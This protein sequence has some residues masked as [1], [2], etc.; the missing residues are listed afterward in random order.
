MHAP[1]KT[2][3]LPAILAATAL[4]VAVLGATPLGHAAGTLVLPKNSVR[5]AQVVNGSL[6]AVDLSKKARSTLKG[7]PGTQGPRGAVG[8]AGAPGQRGATGPQGPRGLPGPTGARATK[9]LVAVKAD[10]S[11]TRS[12]GGTI[13]VAHGT[14][15]MG[16]YTVTFPSDIS[17]CYP[18]ANIYSQ[19]GF[20]VM[21]GISA[22]HLY[23]YT[24]DPNGQYGDFAFY[25]TVYC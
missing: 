6:Q 11:I 12:L 2:P 23:L 22:N 13:G 5:S 10:G 21:N 17:Q 1:R 19:S 9:Y 14:P 16:E 20:V 4:L 8:P 24:R 3:R 18:V 7:A 25:L 15:G